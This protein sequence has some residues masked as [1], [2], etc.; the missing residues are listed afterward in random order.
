MLLLV[1]FKLHIL[2]RYTILTSFLFFVSLTTSAFQNAPIKD[3]L[4]LE[5][6]LKVLKTIGAN[7]PDSIVRFADELILEHA[8]SKQSTELMND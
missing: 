2:F 3:S 1:K 4:Q 5:S 7:N 6:S 8:K